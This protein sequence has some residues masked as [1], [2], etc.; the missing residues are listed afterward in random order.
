MLDVYLQQ[1]ENNSIFFTLKK[2]W[3]ERDTQTAEGA[4]MI[5]PI[6]G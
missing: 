6:L 4:R 2:N 3:V 1:D 5:Y